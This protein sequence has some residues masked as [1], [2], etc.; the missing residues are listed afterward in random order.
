MRL[1]FSLSAVRHRSFLSFASSTHHHFITTTS[2][3]TH[4]HHHHQPPRFLPTVGRRLSSLTLALNQLNI[5]MPE[6][7]SSSSSSSYSTHSAYP[8]SSKAGETGGSTVKK[9]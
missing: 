7:I 4:H 8:T 1:N 5:T 9:S 3:T 2:S 6:H